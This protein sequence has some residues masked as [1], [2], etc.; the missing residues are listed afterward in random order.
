VF[1]GS[2]MQ[3]Q[4]TQQPPWQYRRP[5][6]KPPPARQQI[7]LPFPGQH[8][9]TARPGT[10]LQSPSLQAQLDLLHWWAAAASP[11]PALG[12]LVAL[13]RRLLPAL[14]LPAGLLSALPPPPLLPPDCRPNG[15]WP[16]AE[17]GPPLVRDSVDSG[18]SPALMLPW[19]SVSGR[20]F[21]ISNLTDT[22]GASP[23]S[24]ASAVLSP[25]QRT[26]QGGT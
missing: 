5:N 25:L 17:R 22:S 9:S 3:P 6:P 23:R 2:H 19:E 21:K 14:P 10:H 15:G 16:A 18:L 7:C 11:P 20:S 1:P 26:G 12:V 8:P 13:P 4:A 24:P